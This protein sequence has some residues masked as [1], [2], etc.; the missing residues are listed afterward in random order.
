MTRDKNRA[1][2]V[3]TR[4]VGVFDACQTEPDQQLHEDVAR[5]IL[6]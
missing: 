6:L 5:I 4:P 3:F 2:S 1:V